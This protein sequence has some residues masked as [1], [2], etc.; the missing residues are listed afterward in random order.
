MPR[1]VLLNAPPSGLREENNLLALTAGGAIKRVLTASASLNFPSIAANL[2]ADLT[3]A[4]PGAKAGDAVMVGAPAALEGA[5]TVIGFV[6]AAD[7]VTVRAG[8]NSIGAVDA[9][10]ATYNVVVLG[11]S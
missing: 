1:D 3:I 4:V 8:N 9:A 5:L 6:S 2:A 10:A 7:V 11:L